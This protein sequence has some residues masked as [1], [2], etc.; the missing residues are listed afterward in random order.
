MNS[1]SHLRSV[2]ALSTPD[3]FDDQQRLSDL[4]SAVYDAAIEASLWESAIE[5]VAGFVGGSGGGLFCKDVG[6]PH[7]SIPH[8]VRISDAVAGCSLST[9]L[10]GRRGALS[11][12]PRTAD[13]DHRPDAV[14]RT[15][16]E[17]I[18][19]SMGRAPGPGRFPERGGRQDNRQRCHIRGLPPRTERR[20]RRPGTP[21]DE[22]DRAAYQ[23]R[24]IDRQNVRVQ[25]GGS[26]DIRRYARWAQCRH[27]SGRCGRAPH[28]CQC[29]RPSAFLV[30]AIF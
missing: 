25:G 10:S 22:A 13:R 1:V 9:D 16:R 18:V 17:R 30:R 23:A 4:I 12:R 27:V 20:R 29:G 26:R 19:S 2:S 3:D 7:A 15:R 28:S 8:R 11:R 6:V 5:R 24:R 14:R 21:A